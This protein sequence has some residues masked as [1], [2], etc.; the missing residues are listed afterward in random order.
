MSIEVENRGFVLRLK[1]AETAGDLLIGLLDAAEVLTEAV[2]IELLVG[3]DVPQPA[4]I[5]ADLVG[6]DYPAEIAV[7]DAAELELEVD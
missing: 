2:L 5:G 7:P 4:A 3:L 6:E 1:Q